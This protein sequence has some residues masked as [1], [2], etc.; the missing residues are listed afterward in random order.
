MRKVKVVFKDN[1]PYEYVGE[2]IIECEAWEYRS[3]SMLF[4]FNKSS[5]NLNPATLDKLVL[6]P[7]EN[8]L[9]VEDLEVEG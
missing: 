3:E 5:H 9:Y 6:I 4:L 1:L 2:K 7:A 8:V